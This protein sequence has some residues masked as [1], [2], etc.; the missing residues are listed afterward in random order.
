M[1]ALTFSEDG[2]SAN[3][4]APDPSAGFTT[5]ARRHGDE[6][7][8]SGGNAFTT[9]GYSWEGE[10]PEFFSVACRAGDGP[11]DQTLSVIV[12]PGDSP[13]IP[14]DPSLDTLGHCAC[15]SPRMMFDE[16]RVPAGP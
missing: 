16:V 6:W 15:L 14:Y 13:G 9:N 4:D 5:T 10:G 8:I 12:V 1:A 7:V 3:L 2:G 11:S